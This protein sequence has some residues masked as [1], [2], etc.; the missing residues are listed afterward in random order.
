MVIL[1]IANGVEENI[2]SL[3]TVWNTIT[4]H[5]CPYVYN[6]H[7]HT[8]CSDGQLTPE[9]LIQ[10]AVAI[11]LQGLA[12]TDH[13]SIAGYL[14]AQAWLNE[15]DCPW[16]PKLWVGV[17][18][19]SLLLDTEVH[20]LG[21]GFNPSHG[22]IRPYL[23]GKR[24]EGEFAEA[25]RVIDALHSA[26]GLVILAHPCRYH[27]PYSQLIPAAVNIGIDGVETYYAYNNPKPWQTSLSETEKVLDLTQKYNLLNTCGTDSHGLSILQRI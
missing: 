1:S 20:L 19:T 12:I 17:E 6:F 22:K 23:E 11:G 7:L 18:I 25:A 27:L 5:S 15:H 9:A 26:G 8:N 16:L 13:H 3:K 4:S 10:Q 2:Q 24:P 14:K 21:Y